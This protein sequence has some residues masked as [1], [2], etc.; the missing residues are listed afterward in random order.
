M[1]SLSTSDISSLFGEQ[2]VG[3]LLDGLQV[4]NLVQRLYE[5][6]GLAQVD[7]LYHGTQ[8]AEISQCSPCLVRISRHDDPVLRQFLANSQKD[9]GYLLLS[10]GTWEELL[11]HLRWLTSIQPAQDEDMY[12]RISAPAVA[13]ALFSAEHNPGA[14]L[15][16]PCQQVIVRNASLDIWI[17]YQR[18]GDKTKPSYE[19]PFTPNESQWDAL[20]GETFHQSIGELYQ[21][22]QHF[23]PGYRL[24]LTPQERLEHIE[25][26]VDLAICGG[27]TSKRDI[28]LY[29]NVFGFLGGN[30]EQHPDILERL[31]TRSESTPFQRVN[32]AA[33]LAA[34]R[35]AQ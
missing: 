6:S 29:A 25:Q 7:V 13:R 17:Q 32:Q 35:S 16:G 21:H 26:L 3:L 15:F 19:Q 8:W 11:A 12:L 28:W 31:T 5:W 9:W 10:D 22:M 34:E 30:I 2:T 24:D 20:K 27:F 18:S 33:E 1:N 14:D 23:F 4:E